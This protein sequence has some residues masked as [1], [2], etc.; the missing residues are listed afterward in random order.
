SVSY[1]YELIKQKS[2]SASHL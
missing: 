2:S 1:L